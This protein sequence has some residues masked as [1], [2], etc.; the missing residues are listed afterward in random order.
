MTILLAILMVLSMTCTQNNEGADDKTTEIQRAALSDTDPGLY[1]IYIKGIVKSTVTG[2]GVPTAKII[3]NGAVSLTDLNGYFSLT[4]N[5]AE[6]SFLVIKK[7]YALYQRPISMFKGAELSIEIPLKPA[8]IIKVIN[9]ARVGGN[10]ITTLEGAS[11]TIPQINGI[12]EL[13]SVA[14]TNYNVNTPD[15]LNV[16]GDFTATDINGAPAVLISAGMIDVLVLGEQTGNRYTLDGFGPFT[17]QIPV[18]GTLNPFLPSIPLWNFDSSTGTWL[19]NKITPEA[20][21]KE[22][23]R[24]IILKT[25]RVTT[26]NA[27]YKA[28]DTTCL[29]GIISGPAS[30]SYRIDLIADGFSR[31]FYTSNE[32]GFEIVNIPAN[33]PMTVRI[34]NTSTGEIQERVIVT[35]AGPDCVDVG[36]FIFK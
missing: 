2:K 36:D 10:T 16:P 18:T 29:K 3:A 6:G 25:D 8:D 5:S 34:T 9:P 31:T 20:P 11:I 17:V 7:G 24:V 27:D 26:F 23:N 15:I 4:I 22:I 30:G 35:N 32:G 33:T 13:L 28:G 14:V 21:L 1:P 19:Q 12:M